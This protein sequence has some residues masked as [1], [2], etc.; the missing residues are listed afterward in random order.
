MKSA[1]L[2]TFALVML[3]TGAVDSVRNLPA[4]SIVGSELI[5][6]FIFS[7]IAFL[8]PTSL[9]SAELTARNTDK[10]GIFQWVREAFGEHWAFLAVW[11]QWIS[12]LVWFPTMLSFIAGMTAYLFNPALAQNKFYLVSVILV[13][14]WAL[15][16]IN[17]KGL[18]VSAKMTTFCTLFG[19]AFPMLF[20]ITLAVIW[21]CHGN[22]MQVRFT[23]SSIIPSF[24]HI[25]SW[26]SLTA[27][28]T[29][30]AGMELSA[31]HIKDIRDP[32]RTFPRALYISVWLILVT[33]ILGSLAI[34]I[35]L[36][37]NQISLV[38]G[39]MQS[40]TAFLEAYHMQWFTPIITV[41]LLIGSL[42]GIVSWVISPAKGLLQ[43]AQIGYLPEFL[44]KENEHGVAVNLLIMQ[45]V[46]VSGVCCGF[47]FMPSVS[48][49]YWLLT[50]LSTQ[51]YILM[52]VMMFIAGLYLRFNKTPA[53]AE[54]KRAFTIPGGKIGIWITS[55]LGFIGCGITLVV[56]F[57]PPD[58]VNVGSLLRYEMTFCF[59]MC[60][61]LLPVLGF[62][63][64]HYLQTKRA[65]SL[66][67]FNPAIEVSN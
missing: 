35:V 5:F 63:L 36:P 49:S 54:S 14:F 12:N 47:L 9:V 67:K 15:T 2:T 66:K 60:A 7:A 42:G 29:A 17:L 65:P 23:L 58:G 28:M 45:A 31:V 64:Y 19:M 34:A 8:I 4:I 21:V 53:I 11:L 41:M 25:D 52:Y 44:Q 48:A 1:G 20:I 59:G 43:A 51:L 10:S 46:I 24:S 57:F 26:T 56:G 3:I 32:Q 40:F 16:F 61:M 18:K 50:A 38:N 30:F 13:T 22:P 6:F 37:Q 55:I 33:M 62:Y 27:I 39:V